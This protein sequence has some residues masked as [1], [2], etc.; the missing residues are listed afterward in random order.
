MHEMSPKAVAGLPILLVSAKVGAL[1]RNYPVCDHVLA[2]G[3]VA[4]SAG[5]RY[6]CKAVAD[7]P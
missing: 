7:D 2:E 3:G 6:K 4:W 1:V 5:A